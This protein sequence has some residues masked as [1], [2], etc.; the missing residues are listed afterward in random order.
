MTLNISGTKSG[1]NYSTS[2]N[3]DS[4]TEVWPNFGS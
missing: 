2:H 1:G 3:E 4:G